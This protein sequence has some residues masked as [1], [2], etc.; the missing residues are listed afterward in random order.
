[1]SLPYLGKTKGNGS[2]DIFIKTV[3]CSHYFVWSKQHNCLSNG[4][5][6]SDVQGIILA[7]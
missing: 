6:P 7:Y 4:F 3:V 1:M 5:T 2:F